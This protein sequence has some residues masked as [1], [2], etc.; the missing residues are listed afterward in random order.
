MDHVC[1]PDF[2]LTRNEVLKK[3]KLHG[4]Y[5][6][7]DRVLLAE[8]ALY[9][10]FYKVPECL[11]FRRAHPLQSTA[12]ASDRRSRTVWFNP[13]NRSKLLFPHFREFLEYLR[14]INRA[15]VSLRDRIWCRLEMLRWLK[16]N[17]SRLYSDLELTGRDLVRPIK[18][19]LLGS[20]EI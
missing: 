17:R 16:T 11:F 1:E 3:T 18:N 5:A 10:R 9:G 6:D 4:D 2:G 15:P 14:A 12:I 20:G 8:L 7:S 19:A 13:E